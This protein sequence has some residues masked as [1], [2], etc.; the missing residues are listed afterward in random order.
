MHNFVALDS[1]LIEN[2]ELR[3]QW[4]DVLPA[5]MHISMTSSGWM[6]IGKVRHH[7]CDIHFRNYEPRR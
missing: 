1:A 2:R 7:P 5:G 3:Q 6:L 4:D